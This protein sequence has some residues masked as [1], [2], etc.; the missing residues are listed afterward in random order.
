MTVKEKVKLELAEEVIN[1]RYLKWYEFKRK[2][3]L[4]KIINFF[5]EVYNLQNN[6]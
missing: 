4:R 1:Y 2:R 6:R 3:E 5:F